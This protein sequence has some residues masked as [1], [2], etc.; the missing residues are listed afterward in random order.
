MT[1]SQRN[2]PSLDDLLNDPI[3]Q[4]LMRRDAVE[5]DKLEAMIARIRRSRRDEARCLAA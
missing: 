2:E 3:V 1:C 4:L 5:R